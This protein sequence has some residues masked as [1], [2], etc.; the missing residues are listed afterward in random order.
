MTRAPDFA[1]V[2]V[3][4]EDIQ[5]VLFASDADRRARRSKPGL[6]RTVIL[7]VKPFKDR[8]D[9]FRYAVVRRMMAAAEMMKREVAKPW[10]RPNPKRGYTS[11]ASPFVYAVATRPIREMDGTWGFSDEELLQKLHQG[12]L[13][14]PPEGT[15]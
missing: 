6:E 5:R 1:T 11:I 14:D 13:Q 2:T 15:A 12:A 8:D 7:I 9:K 4:A 3:T 10:V